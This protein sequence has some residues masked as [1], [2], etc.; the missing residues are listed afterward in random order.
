[1]LTSNNVSLGILI[2]IALASLGLITYDVIAGAQIQ[3]VVM[4]LLGVVLGYLGSHLSSSQGADQAL[5]TPPTTGSSTA[6]GSQG[7]VI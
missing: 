3:Q 5:K 4:T 2:L 1:M 7:S 6:D